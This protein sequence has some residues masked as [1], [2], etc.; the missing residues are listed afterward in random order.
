MKNLGKY[1]IPHNFSFVNGENRTNEK[2]GGIFCYGKILQGT[3]GIARQGQDKIRRNSA[4]PI[5]GA[6][7]RPVF[8]NV[9]HRERIIR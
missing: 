9:G 4:Q 5:V 7:K 6:A 8:R 3:Q 2:N 1:I